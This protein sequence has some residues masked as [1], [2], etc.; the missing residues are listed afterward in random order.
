MLETYIVIKPAIDHTI[1]KH[2]DEFI[3]ITL[4]DN[5]IILIKQLIEVL[6]PFLYVLCPIEAQQCGGSKRTPHTK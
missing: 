4:S 3:N 6:K 2:P 5:E 1:S